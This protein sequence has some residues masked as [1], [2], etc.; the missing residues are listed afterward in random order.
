M[1]S[2]MPT[3]RLPHTG[4]QQPMVVPEGPSRA[5]LRSVNA[6]A[7]PSTTMANKQ[8]TTNNGTTNSHR[9]TTPVRNSSNANGTDHSR[10]DVVIAAA[11]ATVA[12]VCDAQVGQVKTA[13]SHACDSEVRQLRAVLAEACAG[14]TDKLRSALATACERELQ[15]VSTSL[16][17]ACA[18]E[19]EL[20]SGQCREEVEKCK[21]SL[22]EACAAE[23]AAVREA[24]ASEVQLV[25][26]SLREA[27]EAEVRL[28]R[29][30]CKEEVQRVKT[31][32]AAA[33]QHEVTALISSMEHDFGVA[34]ARQRHELEAAA[35]P[36]I[37]A[38]HSA[39]LHTSK[40]LEALNARQ[41]ADERRVRT[42]E[43]QTLRATQRLSHMTS[44]ASA[45]ERVGVLD[46]A[47]RAGA[48]FLVLRVA[49]PE[50][51]LAKMLLGGS[52]K[53]EV[54]A[55]ILRL[56]RD[57]ET[58]LLH[59]PPRPHVGVRADEGGAE[60]K[61]RL[62]TVSTVLLGGPS[63]CAKAA[64]IELPALHAAHAARKGKD[65]D[66]ASER[67]RTR[68]PPAW[69]LVTLQMRSGPPI[70]L[71]AASAEQALGWAAGLAPLLP[72][73][74]ATTSGMG[75]DWLALPPRTYAA[76]LW[77]RV[78]LRLDALAA[79][80]RP[81]DDDGDGDDEEVEV[82]EEGALA[83]SI[84]GGTRLGALAA[85]LHGLAAEEQAR[86][87]WVT[88]QLEQGARPAMLHGE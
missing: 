9:S 20:V 52:P 68:T 72:A 36:Y 73:D 32:L 28:V 80:A 63:W 18:R 30:A 41:A 56:S 33:C 71:C 31:D 39:Q 25:K 53:L 45:R 50:N 17:T 77:R 19:V 59:A 27:C 40:Q 55:R 37:R 46:A 61:V 42:L 51:A 81:S 83:Q 43:S 64:T 84:G 78:R 60:A 69:Q 26:T 88:N 22:K 70:F 47:M 7:V 12:E 49:R 44:E 86:R 29:D 35:E 1:F 8:S 65:A 66:E 11:S 38:V 4:Q 2:R 87:D 13:L 34:R 5:A 82:V 74:A 24:C 75:G 48:P 10:I 79:G 58:L 3:N 85:V 16:A 54:E 76:L 14:E 62:D 67:R 57:G 6:A 21:T 15:R 23:V